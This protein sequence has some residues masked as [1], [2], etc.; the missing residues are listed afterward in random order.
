MRL[1]DR[2]RFRRRRR[3]FRRFR[4]YFYARDVDYANVAEWRWRAN[5]ESLKAAIRSCI[6]G[7]ERSH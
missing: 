7:L 5:G 3:R 4:C 1:I 2:R 6:R